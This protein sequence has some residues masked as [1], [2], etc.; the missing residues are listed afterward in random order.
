MAFASLTMPALGVLLLTYY[1]LSSITAW[2][3][4]RHFPGPL[5]GSFSYYFIAKTNRLGKCFE[6]YTNVNRTFGPLARIGPNDL[7]TDD[8]ELIR[9]MS[10]AR[11]P[12][13]RSKWYRGVRID[14]QNDAMGTLLD[15]RAHDK[16][17]AKTASAYSGKENPDLEAGIDAQL[18]N[19]VDYIR[20]SYLTT[21]DELRPLDF[22]LMTQYFT[23]DA[24]TRLAYGKEF[25]HLATDSDAFAYIRTL[26]ENSPTIQLRSD[27]PWMTELLTNPQVSKVMAP[28]ATDRTG[29]GK[30]IA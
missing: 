10:A 22:A 8:P 21:G 23:L 7:I 14:A 13:S 16:L 11:S 29:L 26:R 3:R 28:K 27:V 17:K 5:S 25:G 12:Y 9:R 24:I 15:I 19:V 4:L 20:R 2:Y 1:V 6:T 30:L 18:A